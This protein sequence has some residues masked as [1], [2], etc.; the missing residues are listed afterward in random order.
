MPSQ[1]IEAGAFIIVSTGV[2]GVPQESTTV[3]KVTPLPSAAAIQATTSAPNAS[4]IVKGA[5]ITSVKV[6]VKTASGI[7]VNTLGLAGLKN[8][9]NAV[10]IDKVQVLVIV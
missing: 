2:K 4:G 6:W 7:T 10:G 3:G 9:F 5:R 1:V 8:P